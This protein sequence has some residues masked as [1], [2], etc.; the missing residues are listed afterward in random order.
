MASCDDSRIHA[1][2]VTLEAVNRLNHVFDR[3]LREQVGL[4]QGWFEALLRIE[5]S[6]G[7]MTMGRLAGQIALTSGGVTRLVDRLVDVG[8]AERLNCATDRR[9]QYVGITPDGQSALDR[10]LEVHL[11]DLDREFIGR[12]TA[13]ELTVLVAVMDR[14]RSPI[15]CQPI[16]APESPPVG[17]SPSPHS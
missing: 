5:R 14:L 2:G 1:Y 12:M 10:A 6:G 11:V 17:H 9:V 3:S 15:D 4:G 7:S 16:E 13:D 8:Y